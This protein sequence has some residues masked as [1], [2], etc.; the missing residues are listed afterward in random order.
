LPVN[1]R[2][3]AKE[4]S[5]GLPAET[6]ETFLNRAG[7]RS[8]KLAQFLR[9]CSVVGDDDGFYLYWMCI[10]DEEGIEYYNFRCADFASLKEEGM[11][12]IGRDE[13]CCP[14]AWNTKDDSL[15]WV[16]SSKG[17]LAIHKTWPCVE[18][19]FEEASQLIDPA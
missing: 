12:I 15:A 3:A 2:E 19:L 8:E 13:S 1:F 7:I 17:K 6:A 5:F 11:F 9:E 10:M 16:V 4:T 14:V 18:N